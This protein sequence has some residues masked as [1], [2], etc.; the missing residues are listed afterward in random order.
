MKRSIFLSQC[1]DHLIPLVGCLIL[2]VLTPLSLGA[3]PDVL[4]P[5]S[6]LSLVASVGGALFVSA[7]CY[8]TLC[9]G[10]VGRTLG[11]HL[12]GLRPRDESDTRELVVAHLWESLS[13]ACP[14][15]WVLDILARNG[16]KR[17]GFD[18]VFCYKKPL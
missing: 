16:G 12:F 15:L 9:I 14:L 17:I 8:R 18:Y 6:P 10:L 2:L 11:M 3:D 4:F 7:L 1:L 13:L 5:T